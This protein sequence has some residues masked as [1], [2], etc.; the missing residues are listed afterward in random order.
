MY[1][2]CVGIVQVSDSDSVLNRAL[3]KLYVSVL[4]SVPPVS[5]MGMGIGSRSLF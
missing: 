2:E 4:G 1:F 5:T 3:N